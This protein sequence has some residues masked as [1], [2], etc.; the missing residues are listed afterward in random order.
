LS[1]DP[2]AEPSDNERTIIR[3][4]PG[5]TAKAAARPAAPNPP[6]QEATKVPTTGANP[7][8]AAAAP[9][10]A[11]AIRIASARGRGPDIE[12]LRRGMVDAVRGFEKTALAT[13]LDTKS[14]RAA[15]YAICATID[16]IVLSTPWGSSSN[17]AQQTLTSIFHNEVIGGDRFFDILEQ[18][19]RELGRHS[20]VVELMYLC[21]SLGFEGRYRVMP[22]GVAALTELREGVY[23]AIRTRRG[24]FERELSPNWRG[25]E[26]GYRPLGHRI[27]F[28]AIGLAALAMLC[29]IYMGFNFALAGKSDIAF[30][31][32]FGLPPNAAPQIVRNAAVAPPPPPP[33]PPMVVTQAGAASKLHQFLA[34]EIKQGLVV[35]FEDAQSV[36]VRLANKSMFASGSADLNGSYTSLLERIGEALNDEKGRVVVTGYTDNQPIKTIRFPSNFQLSQARADAVAAVVATKLTDKS[37]LKAEGRGDADPLASNATADGRQQNRRTEVVLV[38]S[39]SDT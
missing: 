35:V 12:Q 6:A 30:A 21:T 23:R 26:A 2:F 1:D 18:M 8:V 29:I 28:W 20:E 24:E 7:L 27:P 5:G 39:G 11:A 36:T 34:P 32:L 33:P 19:S 9:V 13:G 10:L 16:D 17:W 37:R 31:E 15:R 38:R 14:L 3:P 4:R 25:T 22:R